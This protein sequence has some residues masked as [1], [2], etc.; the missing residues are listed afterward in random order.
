M[1]TPPPSRHWTT[2]RYL[3]EWADLLA[4]DDWR[5][6]IGYTAE[7]PTLDVYVK[8]MIGPAIRWA[9]VGNVGGHR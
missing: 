4:R 6:F 7:G 8:G 1:N 2:D 3:L 5:L 9:L